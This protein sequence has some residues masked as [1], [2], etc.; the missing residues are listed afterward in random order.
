MNISSIPVAANYAGAYSTQQTGQSQIR[1]IE[2][3][4]QA[5]KNFK[6]SI[7]PSDNDYTKEDAIFRQRE[8]R[9]TVNFNGVAFTMRRLTNAGGKSAE[10][11]EKQLQTDGISKEIEWDYVKQDFWGIGFRADKAA[12]TIEEDDF[13]RKTNFLASRYV[14]AEDKIL[15]STS[16]TTRTEQLEKLNDLYQKALNEIAEGYSGIV[17][18]YLEK[19]GVYGERDKIYDSVVSGME[20]KIEVYRKG[21]SGNAALESLKGTPDEWL[22]DD[23]AYVAS[24]LR[25]SVSIPAEVLQSKSGDVPYSMEDLDTLG[26]YVSSLSKMDGPNAHDD[27]LGTFTRDESRLG[28]EY[29]LL[30]IKTEKLQNSGRVS[31][32]MS[33]LLQK[34]MNGFMRFYLERT[35]EKLSENRARGGAP[36]DTKGFAALDRSTV[37]DVYRYTMQEYRNSGDVIKALLSGVKYGSGKT[38]A[39][40]AE[41]GTYRANNTSYFWTHFF[42]R[43]QRQYE[44]PDSSYQKYLA[45]M[46]DFEIRLSSGGAVRMNLE[47]RGSE[48]YA[49]GKTSIVE[50]KV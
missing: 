2:D 7:V 14:A 19:N 38:A 28:V 1:N 21:L 46:R 45:G 31:D 47:L 8:V 37:W 6:K 27:V 17:G 20:S 30:N 29:A 18:S 15:K 50:K 35:D 32:S 39:A 26:Q 49:A 33:E 9:T 36:G 24:V 10:E 42:E 4:K 44:S 5:N 23:D 11:F 16:G 48:Y 13:T 34:T 22:L 12:Y 3:F 41:R 43:N 40:L 25:A